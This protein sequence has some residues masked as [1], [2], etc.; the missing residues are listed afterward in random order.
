MIDTTSEGH[1]RR[2]G[3]HPWY[4]ILRSPAVLAH[5]L[6]VSLRGPTQL[7]LD[8]PLLWYERM[9][10]LLLFGSGHRALSAKDLGV[11]GAVP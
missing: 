10:A 6:S 7:A 9:I 4:S 8:G 11:D 5:D 1:L 2:T 3:R